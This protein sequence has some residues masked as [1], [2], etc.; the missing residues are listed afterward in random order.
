MTEKIGCHVLGCHPIYIRKRSKNLLS[1]NALMLLQRSIRRKKG[2]SIQCSQLIDSDESSLIE[3]LG[4][5]SSDGKSK[6]EAY[7]EEM[8][9]MTSKGAKRMMYEQTLQLACQNA[10]KTSNNK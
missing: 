5:F 4:E 8:D 7:K 9:R 2:M 1:L 3:R 6:W 10:V